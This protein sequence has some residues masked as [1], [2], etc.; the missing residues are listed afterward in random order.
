MH[1][2]KYASCNVV[3]QEIEKGRPY[4]FFKSSWL[5]NNQTQRRWNVWN[6]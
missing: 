1:Y 2:N 3:A 4:D 6:F 5:F